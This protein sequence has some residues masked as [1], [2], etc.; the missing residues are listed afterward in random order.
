MQR[1]PRASNGPNRLG[2]ARPPVCNFEK[3]NIEHNDK[4][5]EDVAEGVMTP[6]DSKLIIRNGEIITGALD[7]KAVGAQV[8][9]RHRLQLQCLWRIPTAAVS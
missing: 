9:G 6:S 5:D 1:V 7:K 3:A 8:N 4:D 2:F